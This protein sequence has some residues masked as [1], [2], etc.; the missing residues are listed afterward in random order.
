MGSRR[1][2]LREA[3]HL[4]VRAG[5]NH[6]DPTKYVVAR[7]LDEDPSFR[8]CSCTGLLHRLRHASLGPISARKPDGRTVFS[9]ARAAG[10]AAGEASATAWYP[11]PEGVSVAR[12]V[13]IDLA[14][15][16]GVDVLREFFF[17]HRHPQR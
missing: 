12:H 9:L 4:R 10:V 14:S 7:M 13:A 15:A 16:V 2:R 3:V 1:R 11:R 5:G 6:R 8:P 17:H